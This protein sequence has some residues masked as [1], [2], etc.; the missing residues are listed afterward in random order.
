[1]L[2]FVVPVPPTVSRASFGP[3]QQP[4][5]VRKVLDEGA[6]PHPWHREVL[7]EATKLRCAVTGGAFGP[8]PTDVGLEPV[9]EEMA[10]AEVDHVREGG[11]AA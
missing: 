5:R 11:L 10:S 9:G 1:M 3:V 7:Q 6:K 4:W 8:A 2:S